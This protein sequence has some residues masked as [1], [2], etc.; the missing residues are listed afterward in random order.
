MILADH[1]KN[2]PVWLKLKK[3]YEE[4]LAELRAKNDSGMT[5]EQTLHLRGQIAEVKRLL[6]L[7]N[8]EIVTD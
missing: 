1:E 8:E 2:S 6:E 7:G 4:R 5:Y 3:R